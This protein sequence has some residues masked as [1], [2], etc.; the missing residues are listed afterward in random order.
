MQVLLDAARRRGILVTYAEYTHRNRLGGNLMDGPNYFGHQDQSWISCAQD[1]T[2]DAQT[3]DEL[4]P[5]PGDVVFTKSRGS[6]FSGTDLAMTLRSR[7]VRT[8]ILTGTGSGGCV[9]FTCSDALMHGFYSVTVTDAVFNAGPGDLAMTWMASLG[10]ECT[11]EE[12]LETWNRGSEESESMKVVHGTEVLTTVDEW[13]DPKRTALVVIDMQNEIVCEQG[14]YAR[15]GIDTSP[16]RAIVPSIQRLLDAAR[17]AGVV[18]VFAEYIHRNRFGVNMVDGANYYRNKDDGWVPC[19]Q[20]GT[21]EA[22]TCDEMPADP[23]DLVFVRSRGS[24]FSGNG[25]R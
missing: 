17:R 7:G 4:A 20:E 25:L 1:G 15:Q 10:P 6:S 22:Q 14:G 12:L 5:Q 11:T 3:V 8:L 19:I 21:W 9:A 18:V 13:I 2:W 24:I 23:R 16:I